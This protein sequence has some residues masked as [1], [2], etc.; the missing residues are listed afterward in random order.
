MDLERTPRTCWN[1]AIAHPLAHP[2][3]GRLTRCRDRY[4][5]AGNDRGS[6]ACTTGA[7]RSPGARR[8]C[9]RPCT[10]RSAKPRRELARFVTEVG[11]GAHSSTKS[12]S[13]GELLEQW[14]S[15]NEAD[16]SPTVVNSYR[17]IIDRQLVPRFGRT[18]LRR[19]TTATSICS[20]H[21]CASAVA[22]AGGP[23]APASVKRVHAVLRR[24]LAQAVKWGLITINPCG[25]RVA[26]AR[27]AARG[28][29]ARS[30]G[31][32]AA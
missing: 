4:D 9:R 5:N 11:D 10:A 20:T 6:C 24:A 14:F 3:R 16:W 7:T 31:R 30:C 13:V 12:T 23:L 32:G 1:G 25:E 15:H 21:S 19:L 8:T 17:R 28:V 18:P 27:A 26:A 29:A 2:F 22:R